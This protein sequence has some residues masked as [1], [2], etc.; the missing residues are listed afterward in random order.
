MRIM[1]VCKT[2]ETQLCACTKNVLF[3]I[4]ALLDQRSLWLIN[5]LLINCKNRW[6]YKAELKNRTFLSYKRKKD[7][8]KIPIFLYRLLNLGNLIIN[9]LRL[10]FIFRFNWS[11]E[12]PSRS[13]KE[14]PILMRI[15][16]LYFFREKCLK[17]QLIPQLP[18]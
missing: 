11:L 5:S 8:Q 16:I 4:S 7:L 18:K 10:L 12:E 1:R 3:S 17:F 9:I 13:L 2:P 15:H 14:F 6:S